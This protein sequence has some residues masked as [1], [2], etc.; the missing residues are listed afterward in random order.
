M[1]I[2]SNLSHQELPPYLSQA[3]HNLVDWANKQALVPYEPVKTP[4]LAEIPQDI[5]S[6]H[7]LGRQTGIWQPHMVSAANLVNQGTQ[8]APN[9]VF[10]YLN[11]Y[12]KHVV[13][14][15]AHYGNR[16][17]EENILPRLSS[18]FVGIGQH[19]GLRHQ[20]MAERLAR[21]TQEGIRREQGNA[22]ASGYNEA[23]KA[24]QGDMGR[25]LQGANQMG[26]IGGLAH[27]GQ[28][29]DIATLENQGKYQQQQQQAERDLKYQ[30]QT[31]QQNEPWQRIGNFSNALQGIPQQATTM[32]YW[33]TPANPQVNTAGQIG[34]L[35]GQ[36]Y[37]ARLAGGYRKGGKIR[38]KKR[39]F[40]LANHYKGVL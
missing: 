6:A 10:P 25:Y 18:Q 9:N 23:I 12:Q 13:D 37:G 1:P 33:Q 31:Y 30:Q 36:I 17:F 14:N 38:K 5:R 29:A 26:Q 16:N 21:D 35:A 28:L 2:S 34:S 20:R 8:A 3:Y 22:L 32:N 40:S 7:N 24:Y 11:P 4:R 27:A 15:I 19:G 39:K